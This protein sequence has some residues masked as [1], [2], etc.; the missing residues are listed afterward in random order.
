MQRYVTLREVEEGLIKE[1]VSIELKESL[2]FASVYQKIRGVSHW[3]RGRG[4]EGRNELSCWY[5]VCV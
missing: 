1:E 5:G 3:G 2:E 4:E